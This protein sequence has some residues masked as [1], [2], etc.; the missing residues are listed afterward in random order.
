MY[1]ECTSTHKVCVRRENVCRD[2]MCVHTVHA[3]CMGGNAWGM[4]EPGRVGCV[5][6]GERVSH[7]MQVHM[8]VQSLRACVSVHK[9]SV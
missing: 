4:C 1:R 6:R 9:K 3:V 8:C 5:H 2:R 7:V